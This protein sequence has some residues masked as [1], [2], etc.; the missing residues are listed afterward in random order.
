MA[1]SRKRRD[2]FLDEI[3]ELRKQLAEATAQAALLHEYKPTEAALR[4]SEE[5]YRRLFED[6]LTGDYVTTPDGRIS[7]L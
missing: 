1:A 3:R 2:E 7:G 5:R 6:D 4:E